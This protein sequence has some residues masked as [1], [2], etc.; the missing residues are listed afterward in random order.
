MPRLLCEAWPSRGTS[1][2]SPLSEDV[3][4]NKF[5]TVLFWCCD[6]LQEWMYSKTTRRRLIAP[7]STLSNPAP[8]KWCRHWRYCTW[9]LTPHRM[10][11][12]YRLPES[13]FPDIGA[14]DSKP[15]PPS[16]FLGN[17]KTGLS[18]RMYA[19]NLILTTSGMMKIGNAK[20]L[21]P[22]LVTLSHLSSPPH[23]YTSV[24]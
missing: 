11:T 17:F 12:S 24:Y 9:L 2:V 13:D 4:L 1:H 5:A 21:N 18:S 20:G 16:T 23:H 19:T 14:F 8:S 3:P 22:N 10:F 15:Q 7:P 6:Q